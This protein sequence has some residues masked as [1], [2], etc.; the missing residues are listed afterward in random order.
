MM[1]WRYW[2]SVGLML[3]YRKERVLII[4]EERKALARYKLYVTSKLDST[5]VR[6]SA[7]MKQFY[8][9]GRDSVHVMLVRISSRLHFRRVTS[10]IGPATDDKSSTLIRGVLF[11]STSITLR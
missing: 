7:Q 6:V 4:T 10:N 5:A 8:K 2:V 1:G 3:F 9:A 11:P